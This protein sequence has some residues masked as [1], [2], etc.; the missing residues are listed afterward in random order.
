[1]FGGCFDVFGCV[2]KC[3]GEKLERETAQKLP[4]MGVRRVFFF[5]N[6]FFI[7]NEGSGD[8]GTCPEARHTL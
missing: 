3:F 4:R 8:L 6:Y 2:L 1:M 7:Q 5:F